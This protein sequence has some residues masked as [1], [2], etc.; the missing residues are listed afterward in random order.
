MPRHQ[1]YSEQFPRSGSQSMT[2]LIRKSNSLLLP[3]NLGTFF[4]GIL[5]VALRA[6]GNTTRADGRSASQ[7]SITGRCCSRRNSALSQQ[8]WLTWHGG[9]VLPRQGCAD[10][11]C[12]RLSALR[13]RGGR[14]LVVAPEGATWGPTRSA[15]GQHHSQR[16]RLRRSVAGLLE[17]SQFASVAECQFYPSRRSNA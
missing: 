2:G 10:A 3:T 15:G 12:S 11:H 6:P 14:N 9:H 7:R 1:R 5:V 16:S 13:K 17:S 8:T 4:A